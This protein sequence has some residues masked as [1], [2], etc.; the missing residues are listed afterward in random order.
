MNELLFMWTG[1]IV[2][3]L[4]LIIFGLILIVLGIHIILSHVLLPKKTRTDL[5]YYLRN[6]KDIKKYIEEKRV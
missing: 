4:T 1:Y 2:W 6:K 3:L 5:Y